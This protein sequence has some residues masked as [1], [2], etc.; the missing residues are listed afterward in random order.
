M[1]DTSRKVKFFKPRSL[2]DIAC[3]L[4]PMDSANSR[5]VK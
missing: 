1:R 2:L 5:C 4:M 3:S